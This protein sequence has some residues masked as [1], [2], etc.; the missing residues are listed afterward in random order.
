M[1]RG[2]LLLPL[3]AAVIACASTLAMG[4]GDSVEQSDLPPAFEMPTLPDD[5]AATPI[6]ESNYV[7]DEPVSAQ[8]LDQCERALSDGLDS[9][10]CR[11]MQA[12]DAGELAPGTYTNEELESALADAGYGA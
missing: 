1:S 9:V 5:V 2:F 6:H 4:D 8:M 7:S 12:K 3:V 10:A 11:A